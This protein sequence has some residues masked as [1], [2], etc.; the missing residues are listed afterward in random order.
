MEPSTLAPAAPATSD[1]P[2]QPSF[3]EQYRAAT[4]PPTQEPVAAPATTTAPPATTTTT[5]APT[6]PTG[7]DAATAATTPAAA[8]T[9]PTWLQE[10]GG[11]YKSPDEVKQALSSLSTLRENQLTEEHKVGLRLL[12]DPEAGREYVSLLHA[13][14][15]ALDDEAML[16]QDFKAQYPGME[17]A[18]V[19]RLFQRTQD[20]KYPGLANEAD[21]LDH[22][23]DAAMRKAEAEQVRTKWSTQREQK[24][25]DYQK[26]ALKETGPSPEQQQQVRDAHL[27]QVK[28]LLSKGPDGFKLTV[29]VNGT[30]LNL[31]VEA[32]D[33]PAIQSVLENPYA[34]LAK[35]DGTPDYDA[36]VNFALWRTQGA[37]FLG[38][39]QKAAL[40]GRGA[41]VALDELHN[42]AGGAAAAV[43]PNNGPSVSEQLRAAFGGQANKP[44]Y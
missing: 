43:N 29:D 31:A 1:A 20:T 32:A 37:R 10:L 34:A 27:D 16:L 14:Y 44:N 18:A 8:A 42:G 30:P 25:A 2:V 22:K 24:L 13:D 15:Q 21:D 12:N 36:L 41:V 11:E 19:E 9:P 33:L 3:A 38:Q 39:A 5:T 7:T 26:A 35:A 28:T 4:A 40:E 6:T 17:A 23:A